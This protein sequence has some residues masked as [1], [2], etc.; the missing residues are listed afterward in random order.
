MQPGAWSLYRLSHRV[1]LQ[2]RSLDSFCGQTSKAK[3]IYRTVWRRGEV[4][5]EGRINGSEGQGVRRLETEWGGL[6]RDLFALKSA[7][8]NTW[9]AAEGFADCCRRLTWFASAEPFATDSA[10]KEICNL[11]YITLRQ[12]DRQTDCC[13]SLPCSAS[14]CNKMERSARLF[15]DKM[16]S[17]AG[18]FCSLFDLAMFLSLITLLYPQYFCPCYKGRDVQTSR[19]T[20]RRTKLC[21][22]IC[23]CS[24]CDHASQMQIQTAN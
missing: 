4:L 8:L 24:L 21:L 17:A 13:S 16:C 20:K 18:N 22:L 23:L 2:V 10:G 1:P 6:R 19:H 5:K 15:K 12:T 14:F 9:R 3:R 7:D 11:C